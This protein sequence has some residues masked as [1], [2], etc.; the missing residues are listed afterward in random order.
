MQD[1]DE[2]LAVSNKPS[3]M[4]YVYAPNGRSVIATLVKAPLKGPRNWN[5]IIIT[6]KWVWDRKSVV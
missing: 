6:A 4:C 1:W 5:S 3:A 2:S